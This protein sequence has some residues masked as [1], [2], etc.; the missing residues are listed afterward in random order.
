M[1]CGIIKHEAVRE[2]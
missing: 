2:L 1:A